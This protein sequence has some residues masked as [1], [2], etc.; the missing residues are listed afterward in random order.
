MSFIP[1]ESSIKSSRGRP[2]GLVLNRSSKWQAA[3]GLVLVS[4]SALLS[5]R[6][7]DALL[8]EGVVFEAAVAVEVVGGDVEDYGDP[9]MKAF[10]AFELKAGDLKD[11]PGFIGALVDEGNDGDADVAADK[12]G[13]AGFLKDFADQRG[14]GGFAVGA[15]NGQGFAL[16]EARGQ[17]QFADDGQAKALDL[18]EFWSVQRDAG[19]DNDEVLATNPACLRS[20]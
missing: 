1:L 13:K 18:G 5:L 14:G 9:G 12:G 4:S 2:L 10:S 11:R 7:K 3:I 20:V 17:F 16:E 15:G 8:G 19:A 6:G